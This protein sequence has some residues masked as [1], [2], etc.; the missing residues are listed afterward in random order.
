MYTAEKCKDKSMMCNNIILTLGHI[1]VALRQE[2]KVKQLVTFDFC[3]VIP[4][5]CSVILTFVI[6]KGQTMLIYLPLKEV[7]VTRSC[8]KIV[9]PRL[10]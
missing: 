10:K 8:Q 4:T 9:W 7:M 1:A 5:F 2:E 3:S 6:S